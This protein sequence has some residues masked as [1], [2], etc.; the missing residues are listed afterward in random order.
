MMDSIVSEEAGA[1][2]AQ[3]WLVIGIVLASVLAYA[4]SFSNEFVWD[5]VSSVLL[6]K[7]VQNP[8]YFFQ[9]FKEDQHAFGRGQ[10][11]FYR[12]LVAVSFMLDYV[13]SGPGPIDPMAKMPSLDPFVFHLSNLIWHLLA[14]LLLLA[15]LTKL[16][17][18]VVARTIVGFIYAL[19]PFHTEAVTYISG[20]ADMMAAA[21]MFAGVWFFLWEGT[22]QRKIAGGAL[23][24]GCFI[25]ALLCKESAMIFPG[26]LA[27]VAAGQ[28]LR[29]RVEEP[30]SRS[31]SGYVGAVIGALIVL[32]CYGGLRSTVLHFASQETVAGSFFQRLI[33]TGQAFAMYLG[34]LFVPINLHMERT[35]FEVPV[36]VSV[37]GWGMLAAILVG[38]SIAVRFKHA[39][40]FIGLAWFL[41]TWLPISGLF[42]LNA[43][44]AE[45]WMYVPMAGFWWAVAEVAVLAWRH[46][47]GRRVVTVVAYGFVL[48][49]LV[50]TIQR[51]GDWRDNETL[52]KAT[53][54]QNPGSIRVQYNLAVTYQDLLNNQA[55]ARRHYEAVID[56]CRA[57]KKAFSQKGGGGFRNEEVESHLSLG[58]I[59]EKQHDYANAVEHYSVVVNLAPSP[60]TNPLIGTAAYGAGNCLLELGELKQAGECFKKAGGGRARIWDRIF[61]KSS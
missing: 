14:V 35:L 30:S 19:H 2:P 15:V 8:A 47:W 61:R 9:L 25:V 10:G 56:L 12:P 53:L 41:L 11:N 4:N 55:G 48:L 38:I 23:S 7:H 40:L 28:W 60:A 59:F 49:F 45:H 6:N 39:R 57:Q 27:V 18:P 3:R 43:P 17:T 22:P 24:V 51:N 52:Y 20:R 36:W 32:G 42:P 46:A 34:L 58:T 31:V 26:L 44:M 21:F 5:D 1:K 50:L 29:K 33:E 54:A 13:L 37:I 16:D